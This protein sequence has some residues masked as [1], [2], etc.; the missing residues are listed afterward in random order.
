MKKLFL[1]SFVCVAAMTLNAQAPLPVFVENFATAPIN[2]NVEGYNNWYVCLKSSDNLGVSPKVGEGALF[3][4]GYYGSNIGNVAL[5]D[6]LIGSTATGTNGQRISTKIVTYGADTV[7]VANESKTYVAFLAKISINSKKS[8][9]RD[10][11]TLEGSKTSSMT[12]GRIFAKVT[13]AG[14]LTFGV[15]KNTTTMTESSQFSLDVNHLFVLVYE[16]VGTIAS[17]DIVTLYIDPDLSLPEAS[18]TNKLIA[19][20]SQTDYSTSNKFGINLRQRGIGAQIGGIRVGRTWDSVLLGI[21]TGV[22]GINSYNNAISSFGKTIQTSVAGDIKVFN[23]AGAKLLEASATNKV[24][25]NLPAGLYLV[26]LTS[27]NGQVTNGK[28]QIK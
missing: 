22:V 25:T 10:F 13:S 24:L 28:V 19:A 12:R 23:L 26:R 21:G 6:S 4:T 3:Y 16:T 8:S 7:V 18:Q 14:V 20:D 11:F 5:L 15:T 2:G 17:D 9:L 27:S 1:L